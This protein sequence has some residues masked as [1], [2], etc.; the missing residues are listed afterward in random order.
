MKFQELNA[1][2]LHNKEIADEKIGD[3]PTEETKPSY[4]NVLGNS[5]LEYCDCS[6]I[7]GLKYVG[8]RKRPVLEKYDLTFSII[9]F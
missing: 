6:S 1:K 5:F 9:Y 7:I 2:H 3:Q 4:C 8:D